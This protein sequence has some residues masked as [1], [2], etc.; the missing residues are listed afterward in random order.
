MMKDVGGPP[1]GT[2][3]TNMYPQ[4]QQ[5]STGKMATGFNPSAPWMEARTAPVQSPSAAVPTAPRLANKKLKRRDLANITSQLA[6]MLRS[7]VDVTSALKSLARQSRNPTQ[8]EILE[9]IHNDLLGGKS[10][11]AALKPYSHVFGETY[12]AS[13]T[14]GEASGRMPDVLQQL[15]HLQRGELRLRN[16]IR[17]LLAYPVLLASVSSLVLS[18]LVLFVLP[19]FAKIFEQFEMPLPVITQMLLGVS[20]EL[21]GRFW[22]WGP[23]FLLVIVGTFAS[24]F[25]TTGRRLWDKGMLNVFLI[26]DVTRALLIGRVCRLM[27]LMLDSGVPLLESLRLARSSVG[28][29]LYRELFSELESNVLNGRGL[30]DALIHSEFIPSSA[31]EM[32]LTAERTGNLGAVTQL[33]GEHFEDEGEAKLRE[34]VTFLEP[35]ITVIMGAVVAVVVL[36]VMLPMFDIA[37]FANG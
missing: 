12:I 9:A 34:I 6:I 20:L 31:A 11:S 16:T 37:T 15:A 8:R 7:G 2:A 14:A 19:Q 24:R 3:E 23:L 5:T 1:R 32:V 28:N 17:T 29:S 35:A 27:G 13:A 22:L 36:A 26:R 18:A 33:I 25:S 21:R 30:G 4:G 10:F